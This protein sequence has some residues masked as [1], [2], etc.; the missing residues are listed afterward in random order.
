VKK[1]KRDIAEET[2]REGQKRGTVTTVT[3]TES[4]KERRQQKDKSRTVTDQGKWNKEK[5]HEEE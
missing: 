1:E 5:N 4:N 3:R 2:E